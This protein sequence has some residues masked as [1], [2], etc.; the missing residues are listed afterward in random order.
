MV[1]CFLKRSF[2]LLSTQMRPFVLLIFGLFF[3]ASGV[4]AQATGPII[5]VPAAPQA[6]PS[7]N[8]AAIGQ[9]GEVPVSFF[10]GT[11]DISIPLGGTT[12]G[13]IEIPMSLSYHASGF[14][15]D[16]H[17]GWVGQG[18]NLN[19][20]GVIT[21]TVNDEFDETKFPSHP[22]TYIGKI[23]FYWNAYNFGAGDWNTTTPAQVGDVARHQK[24]ADTAPDEFSFSF[25]GY[26][27]K[28]YIDA[29]ASTQAK[30]AWR[31]KCDKRLTVALLPYGTWL[32][33]PFPMPTATS[34]VGEYQDA[35]AMPRFGGFV[36]TT[37][38]G[39][40]YFFGGDTNAI[41]YSIDLFDQYEAIW[42]PNSWYLT[43]IINNDGSQVDFFYTP[44]T[45]IT[46]LAI[47]ATTKAYTQSTNI[48]NYSCSTGFSAT[49]WHQLEGNCSGQLI[50][51]VYLDIIRTSTSTISFARG[52]STE[53]AYNPSFYEFYRNIIFPKR[54]CQSQNGGC[55]G[56][57]QFPFLEG[58]QFLN[59]G[60]GDS[61]A[62]PLWLN[63]IRWQQLNTITIQSGGQTTGF[64]F[65]YSSDLTKRL[66]LL[67]LFEWGGGLVK[68][69]YV[70]RY[71]VDD[72][73]YGS[74]PPYLANK[75]DHWGFYNNK[76]SSITDPIYSNSGINASSGAYNPN[77]ASFREPVQNNT[78]ISLLGMLSQI[79]YPTGGVTDFIF[80]PHTYA[81]QTTQGGMLSASQQLEAAAST[82]TPAGGVRIRLISSYSKD[83]P[84]NKV[85]KEYFYV[86]GYSAATDPSTLQSS[87]VLG[88]RAKYYFD[89]ECGDANYGNTSASASYCIKAFS[90][91]SVLPATS[92]STGTHI[93]YGQ[94]VEK[95]S[96]GS[97]TKYIF[98]SYDTGTGILDEPPLAIVGLT[99]QT[100][101]CPLSSRAE[102]RGKLQSETTFNSN[103][104]RVKTKTIH[105]STIAKATEYVRVIKGHE[106]TVCSNN[107][108]L[109]QGAAY[110][111]YTYSNLPDIITETV[112]DT[113]GRN[114]IT[115]TSTTT[116]N[117][118]KL[119]TSEQVTTSK[120]GTLKTIYKYPRDYA[121]FPAAP[122]TD[123]VVSA[124]S[125][126]VDR[127]IISSPVETIIINQDNKV[128][129]ASLLTFKQF[130]T[131][132]QPYQYYRLAPTTLQAYSGT[133]N[134]QFNGG[135]GTPTISLPRRLT[136][137]DY[138]STGHILGI[139]SEGSHESSSYQ[140]GYSNNLLIAKTTNARPEQ[141]AFTS[142]EFDYPPN[143]G[144]R[145]NYIINN[146][147]IYDWSF[148]T[149]AGLTNEQGQPI[150]MR[151]GGGI[152]GDGYY[153]LNSDPS[154]S[155][156][157]GNLTPGDYDLTF[158]AQATAG[159][160]SVSTNS[161]GQVL[162][163]SD[164]YTNP[165]GYHLL[166]YRLRITN[167]T[168]T[169][170]LTTTGPSVGIDDV[171]LYPVGAQ[172][173][174]YTHRPGIG[175]T[176]L[177]DANSHP[178]FYEY[179]AL[180]RLSVM[181]DKNGNIIKLHEY[182]YQK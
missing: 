167:S 7:P 11:P 104:I 78:S 76:Y 101:Y 20:G 49:L 45:Y 176:S 123:P 63:D 54:Y 21:R 177:S 14:R 12:E 89:N 33:I 112:Y 174:T 48:N 145:N 131:S 130:E 178:I 29:A 146:L 23:G 61:R 69:P 140:W 148:S 164:N 60:S 73:Q 118:D 103:G 86:N 117:D 81:F 35:Y 26:S 135:S 156:S 149:R 16:V 141:D 120:G 91:Q 55:P 47:S 77:Y 153:V 32:P 128:I 129:D 15:P 126:M 57:I 65:R 19:V 59:G 121:P 43:R 41:E 30:T 147:G 50:R 92:N 95:R 68:P 166:H 155:I 62:Y 27:G 90:T 93:G 169:V 2:Y 122:L 105:Y 46:Q 18:W 106:F 182:K 102:E 151:R 10:T 119:P 84:R 8:A 181:R 66:T 163:Q 40:Q 142:F 161:T 82:K 6:L 116:Y 170:L 67:S 22:A 79:Q 42:H 113:G 83:N 58:G 137:T 56:M 136:Y 85:E 37:E 108:P 124:L 9:Y 139:V 4:Y 134:M 175:L 158:W 165:Q 1:F 80:E 115:T 160:M 111:L 74:L 39:T 150:G 70:F 97:F 28:F 125:A 64:T 36:I 127:N 179:D 31:V 52:P 173:T 132:I 152:S 110:K 154:M 13:K 109:G 38:D 157:R 168:G 107:L 3:L 171:R 94:V 25:Q 53:L 98:S 44:S 99:T 96:N 87:G 138:N 114:S 133:G 34:N 100:G 88:Q 180:N 143:S 172:M 75:T 5:G 162:S 159:T 71:N 51:P 72:A 144:S 17:P 24:L